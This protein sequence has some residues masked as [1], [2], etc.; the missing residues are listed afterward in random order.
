M[1]NLQ[2]L[3]VESASDKFRKMINKVP[4]VTIYFWI[5]KVLCTTV[6]ETFSDFLDG[7]FN[8]GLANLTYIM[9]GLL[10]IVLFF[11][12][13]AKK[14]I[15]G[16]YWLAVVLISIVGTLITD[17]LSDNLGVSLITSTIVF[18][19]VLA[20]VFAVWYAVEK[21]LSI[22]SINSFSREVFYWLTVLFTFALG[23][24]AGDLIAEQFGLGY[25]VST[26][27]FAAAIAIIV[28]ANF[29]LKLNTVLAFWLAYIL[30]RP[31]GASIGD[32]LSQAR[33]DGGLGLGPT[34]TSILFLL[35]IL[36]TVTYLSVTKKD[37]IPGEKA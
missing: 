5:I 16:L 28:F 4:E 6:G 2:G 3:G 30:T 15:P 22:K 14:Y 23:T 13:K 17:N 31:L 25:V 27:I 9:G 10:L 19:V 26:V 24:A 12:F 7:R 8:L 34:V 29:R 35:A 18:S 32:L 33:G 1:D 11:Q 37:V 20:A 21:T 36:A